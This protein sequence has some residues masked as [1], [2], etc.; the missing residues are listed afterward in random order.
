MNDALHRLGDLLHRPRSEEAKQAVD[1]VLRSPISTAEKISRIQAIDA[2]RAKPR[3]ETP[4]TAKERVSRQTGGLGGS[5]EVRKNRATLKAFV[6]PASYFDFIFTE[7]PQ[8]RRH[9]KRSRVIEI[10]WI[11]PD[12][13]IN[14]NLHGLL[15]TTLLPEARSISS[16]LGS[17]LPDAWRYLDKYSYNLLVLA[18]TLADYVATADFRPRGRADRDMIDRHH[19]LEVLVLTL[20]SAEAMVDKL[21]EA[22]GRVVDHQGLPRPRARELR[23]GVARVVRQGG[24]GL[25]PYDLVLGL[26]MV[27]V[28]KHLEIADLHQEPAGRL[29]ETGWFDCDAETQREIDDYVQSVLVSMERLDAEARQ[30]QRLLRH[31]DVLEAE[32]ELGP[33]GLLAPFY[34]IG[35]ANGGRSFAADRDQLMLLF[36][37]F[38]ERFLENVEP[39]LSGRFRVEPGTRVRS[40]AA[41]V[42]ELEF[43]TLRGI[44]DRLVRLAFRLR[45]FPRKRYI[46]LVA[47]KQGAIEAETEA[48]QLFD[49]ALSTLRMLATRVDEILE[50]TSEDGGAAA[51]DGAGSVAA[52][53]ERAK[54]DAAKSDA[55]KSDGPLTLRDMKRGDFRLPHAHRVVQSR[56][57]AGEKTVRSAIDYSVGIAVAFLTFMKDA[58][59][60]EMLTRS[61]ALRREIRAKLD[62]LERVADDETFRQAQQ[63]FL[64]YL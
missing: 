37:R 38:L 60:L 21:I 63:R 4:A 13:T 27:K 54:S 19:Q 11:P 8:L 56:F 64:V 16:F 18:R 1:R 59:T 43:I 25:S 36:P 46:Q 3:T 52:K 40:F 31:A 26:N 9:A 50:K 5:R 17:A 49:E 32:G 48:I 57:A 53:S 39:L 14:R 41:E 10:R 7:F 29:I 55:A 42:F 22:F 15:S 62:I 61:E 34:E 12:V 47:T 44:L 2:E 30:S 35:P 23:S 45:V 20:H 6:R 28:R 33:E 58:R 24:A 51:V